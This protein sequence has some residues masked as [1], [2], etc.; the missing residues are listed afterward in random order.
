MGG[1]NDNSKMAE[2]MYS[3]CTKYNYSYAEYMF[4]HFIE[5]DLKERLEFISS[6]ERIYCCEKLNKAKNWEIFENKANTY[7]MYRNYFK[8]DVCVI[9]D[10]KDKSDRD[11]FRKFVNNHACFIGKTLDDA[12]G[13]GIQKFDLRKMALSDELIERFYEKYPKGCLLEE[14]IIQS[15]DFSQ[16]H[17]QSVNTLRITT[18]RFND[19]IEII[20]PAMRIGT[21]ESYVDNAG[22]NGILCAI[23]AET[24]VIIA[25][26]NERGEKFEDHPDTGIKLIGFQIP[27]L[28]E[29]IELAKE[30]ALIV[31]SN[32]Y[33]GW[34]LAHTEKGWVLVEANSYG[35]FVIW[36]IPLQ[37]GFRSE[38]EN[39]IKRI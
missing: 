17:P 25:T 38:W 15:K 32:R 35:G 37:K 18:I 29:A 7:K 1:V 20:H 36:Q 6:E 34:D 13:V 2:D 39:I 28:D 10:F 30:L 14:L 8:R 9:R 33:T 16:F 3:F 26:A 24:G 23:D 31:P 22:S 4:Y 19:H 12:G 11:S 21:G 27:F 5:R